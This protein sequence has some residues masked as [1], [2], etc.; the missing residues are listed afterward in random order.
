MVGLVPKKVEPE[1]ELKCLMPYWKVQG[2]KDKGR[3]TR[4]R[5][6]WKQAG[7]FA[8]RC[9]RCSTMPDISRRSLQKPHAAEQFVIQSLEREFIC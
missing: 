9:S 4:G 1:A 6:R 7:P 3:E 5:E 8:K 2:S